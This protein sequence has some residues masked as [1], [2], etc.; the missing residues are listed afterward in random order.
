MLLSE[1][2]SRHET[3]PED[4]QLLDRVSNVLSGET[5][6]SALSFD[7]SLYN[8]LRRAGYDTV[9]Q[10]LA[11]GQKQ[12]MKADCIGPK[13]AAWILDSIEQW[14]QE[15]NSSLIAEPINDLA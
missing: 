7:R 11:A 2:L 14:Q 13:R 5:L 12:L 6:L 8:P 3:T 4:R 1:A 9:E 10:V 15:K